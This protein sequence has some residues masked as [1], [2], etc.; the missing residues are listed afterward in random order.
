MFWHQLSFYYLFDCINSNNLIANLI[1]I[2]FIKVKY[3]N[4]LC[5]FSFNKASSRTKFYSISSC[6]FY[7]KLYNFFRFEFSDVY[8]FSVCLHPLAHSIDSSVHFEKGDRTRLTFLNL[9]K[10]QIFFLLFNL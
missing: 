7:K 10:N 5:I 4:S 1:I 2:N 3:I 9:K 6:Y 8:N